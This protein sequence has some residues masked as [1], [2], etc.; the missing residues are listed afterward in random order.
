M[1]DLLNKEWEDLSDDE[2]KDFEIESAEEF[3]EIKK[4]HLL[5]NPVEKKFSSSLDDKQR[6]LENFDNL[7]IVNHESQAPNSILIWKIAAVLF[8]FLFF[9]LL[10]RSEI[11]RKYEKQLFVYNQD[12]MI[13]VLRVS[14][15]VSLPDSSELIVLEQSTV[16]SERKKIETSNNPDLASIAERAGLVNTSLLKNVSKAKGSGSLLQ[17]KSWRKYQVASN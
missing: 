2:K 6:V 9:A 3:L 12:N 7:K 11:S 16:I 5:L 17:D 1:N 4:T 15:L 13:E 8:G 10:F 14:P